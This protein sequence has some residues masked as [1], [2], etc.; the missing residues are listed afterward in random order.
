MNLRELFINWLTASR[1]IQSL[2][3]RI[4]EQRQDFTERLAEKDARI[5]EL[6]TDCAGL[7]LECDRMRVILMPLGS[8]AGA[9]YAARYDQP[10]YRPPTD[11]PAF[12]GPM[13]WEA[14]LQQVMEEEEKRNGSRVEG[15]KEVHQQAA[16]DGA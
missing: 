2:E 11:K 10:V 12:E 13:G 6:K 15:R 9:V 8:P 14:E 16:D 4:Q 5:R 1:F 3:A 7:K